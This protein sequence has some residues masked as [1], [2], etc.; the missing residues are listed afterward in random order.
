MA[1]NCTHPGNMIPECDAEFISVQ[2]DGRGDMG[3]NLLEAPEMDLAR[4]RGEL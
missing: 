3:E 2:S 1:S 4:Q